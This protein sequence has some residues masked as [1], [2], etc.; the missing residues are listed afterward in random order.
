MILI[1]YEDGEYYIGEPISTIDVGLYVFISGY[2]TFGKI[3]GYANNTHNLIKVKG[4]ST[5][6]SVSKN[7]LYNIIGSTKMGYKYLLNKKH[8]DFQF[9]KYTP[10]EVIKFYLEYCDNNKNA[11]IDDFDKLFFNMNVTI[12]E[13]ITFDSNH[14]FKFGDV[15]PLLY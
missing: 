1:R 6:F 2:Q 11:T 9:G 14:T 5:Y 4:E 13:D 15:K 3:I 10:K 12:I 8:L 7:K